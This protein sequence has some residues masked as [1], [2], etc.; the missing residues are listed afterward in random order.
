MGMYYSDS[1]IVGLNIND[2][3][4]YSKLYQS[5]LKALGVTSQACI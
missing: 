3:Q 1:D 5:V 4:K 2:N